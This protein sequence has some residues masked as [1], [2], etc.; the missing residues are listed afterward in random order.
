MIITTV[1][2]PKN[3]VGENPVWSPREGMLYWIDVLEPKLYRYHLET[4]KLFQYDTDKPFGNLDLHPNGHIYGVLGND[5]VQVN[6]DPGNELVIKIVVPNLTSDENIRFNDGKFDAKGRFWAGTMDLDQKA[7]RGKLH[8]ITLSGDIRVVETGITVSNGTDF[9]P[10]D[11][12]LYFTDSTRHTIY[13]YDFDLEAGS[14]SNRRD[15]IT[16]QPTEGLPDGI[17]VS[18]NGD[19][20]VAVWTGWRLDRYSSQGALIESI[21][22]PARN[23]TCPAFG[24]KDN[25]LLFTTTATYDLEGEKQ[26]GENAGEVLI[27]NLNNAT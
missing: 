3:C 19:I 16:Y 21:K 17:A 2:N 7:P 10:N 25:T 15:L 14:L 11:D 6:I 26:M 18:P 1:G 20:W 23:I 24:G 5:L 8:R 12:T 27:I 9:S 22:L 4:K 13:A